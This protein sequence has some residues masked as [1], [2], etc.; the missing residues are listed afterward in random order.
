MKFVLAVLVLLIAVVLVLTLC[1]VEASA[2]SPECLPCPWVAPAALAPH[3][4]TFPPDPLSGKASVAWP[5][6]RPRDLRTVPNP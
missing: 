4:P 5:E 3:G 2:P 6:Y 1:S